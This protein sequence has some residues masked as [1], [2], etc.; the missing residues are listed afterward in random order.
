[1]LDRYCTV[2]GGVCSCIHQ[3]RCWQSLL[4]TRTCVK[5]GRAGIAVKR[6]FLI[7]PPRMQVCA[8]RGDPGTLL[9]QGGGL[10]TA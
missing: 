9:L 10:W 2:A 1:M 7:L 6:S 3:L 5:R 8:G 4:D